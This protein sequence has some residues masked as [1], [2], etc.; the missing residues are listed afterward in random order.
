MAYTG[1]PNYQIIAAPAMPAAADEGF[2]LPYPISELMLVGNIGGYDVQL[3]GTIQQVYAQVLKA[4]PELGEK[5]ILPS[6]AITTSR[7][8][9]NA[10]GHGLTPE[11]EDA[12]GSSR[13]LGCATDSNIR[14][15]IAYLKEPHRAG[16]G[17]CWVG[18]KKCSRISCS[19]YS[20]ISLC[21]D[22]DY[23]IHPRCSYMAQYVEAIL[24]KCGT[25]VANEPCTGRLNRDTDN[26][27][28]TV[29]IG[30]C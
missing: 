18:A 8:S 21:N 26:N 7:D 30:K 1:F 28:V 6:A 9:S 12:D 2:E 29:G 3:N 17:D 10:L 4:H 13:K 25:T 15:G 22:N 11:C 23:E 19:Y 14:D 20:A 5:S 27:Y 24:N 16:S